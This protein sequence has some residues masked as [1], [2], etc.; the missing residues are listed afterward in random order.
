MQKEVV[1]DFSLEEYA[2]LPSAKGQGEKDFH[3]LV[4]SEW[5]SAAGDGGAP[6]SCRILKKSLDARR[7]PNIRIQIRL[8]LTDEPE[9][10]V[11][12]ASLRDESGREGAVGVNTTHSNGGSSGERPVVVGFGPA[13][14]L[15]A[16]TLARAGLCPIVLERGKRMDERAKDVETYF[17]TGV[18]C[19][20]S[21]VQ[22]GEG[23][24]GAFSDG[25]LYSGIRSPR[26]KTVLE[27][28]VA[29]GA[30]S[31]ILYEAHPHVGTDRIRPAVSNLRREIE[32][33][34]G[35]FRFSTL[36][37]G[38][39]IEEGTLTGLTCVSDGSS[40]EEFL[41]C[42]DVILAI[43]HSA[44]DTFE[45]LYRQGVT[46]QKKPFSV[47]LRIEHLQT[48]IN[49][50]QYGKRYRHPVLPP[51]EYKLVSPTSTGRSLYTFCMCPGGYVIASA[52]EKEQVVTNGMSLQERSGANA[53]SAILV[54]VVPEDL[55]EDVLSGM[56][57]QRELEHSAFLLGG[58]TGMAPAQLVGDF[59]QNRASSGC[60]SVVP[61]Y[62]P[63]VIYTNLREILPEDIGEAI[64]EGITAFGR[65]L[66]GFDATQSLLTGVETRSS[67]PVRIVRDT[68]YQSPDATGLYPCAEGAG[69]AGGIMSSAVDGIACA[70]ALIEHKRERMSIR[71]RY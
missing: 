32:Y 3:A 42:R 13:G 26:R 53:N 16:L 40:Q 17:L 18:L 62:R 43:G 39:R 5:M 58:G 11:S 29:A 63:G 35:S 45:V 49:Q 33:L 27:A 21:N 19:P 34:G 8:L 51:A 15:A 25:K 38:L 41:A 67:S 56:Y 37:T 7:K 68:N 9:S 30:P 52:S 2:N 6:F 20:G 65:K 31:E 59:L 61:T 22:F 23:G 1:L 44:R 70:E 46:L 50:A 66:T 14:I 55:G 47:G 24:A 60:G 4:L 48:T 54:G 69:Y 64:A 12:F 10:E 71:D 36:M 28:F 57:F